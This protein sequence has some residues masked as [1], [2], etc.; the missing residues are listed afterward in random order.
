METTTE[1]SDQPEE[2]N[3]GKSGSAGFLP[4]SRPPREKQCRTRAKGRKFKAGSSRGIETMLR[5]QYRTH[6]DL[7]HLADNKASI[8]I[9]INGLIISILL[10]TGGSVVA[11]ADNNLY[12]L[13]IIVLLISGFISMIYAVISAR[14]IAERCCDAVKGPDDFLN[15][16]ANVMYFMDN[17]DLSNDEYIEV[18]KEV[19]DDRNLV[20]EEMVSYIHTMSVIIRRKFFLLRTSYSVFIFGL[21]LCIAT[22]IGV[23]GVIMLKTEEG[24]PVGQRVEST[25]FGRFPPA[26]GVYEPSGVHQLADGRVLIVEDEVSRPF[27]LLTF[28]PGGEITS[29]IRLEPSSL[30]GKNGPYRQFRKLNDLE[31]VTADGKGYIYAVTSH[32]YSEDGAYSENRGKLVRFRIAGEQITEPVVVTG[33]KDALFRSFPELKREAGEKGINIEGLAF[34]T[35]QGNMLIGFRFPRDEQNNALIAIISDPGALFSAEPVFRFEP[36]LVRLDLNGG[37]IRGMSYD[38]RLRGYLVVAGD[39]EKGGSRQNQL[40]FW[41]GVSGSSPRKAVVTGLSGMANAEGVA[42]LRMDDYSRIL[43]VSD[44]GNK[45]RGENA[46]FLLIDYDRLRLW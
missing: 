38:P 23:A 11:F 3:G 14:P 25:G 36:D 19:M 6:L 8:M 1:T 31:G 10:A 26:A 4:A 18:M 2:K 33:L 41:S 20:Y 30:F 37:A 22:F 21:G 46:H 34:D 13:P 16:K 45:K 15:G 17:A 28:S 5:S 44:D 24:N 40:W 43:V 29:M 39:A 35:R 42:P 32:S 12:I 27:S 7:T 9:T